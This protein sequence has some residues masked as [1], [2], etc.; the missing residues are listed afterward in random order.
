MKIGS[1]IIDDNT[2]PFLIAEIG[3]NHNGDVGIARKLI[4]VAKAAGANAVKFQTFEAESLVTSSAPLANYQKKNDPD[5]LSQHAML[6]SLELSRNEFIEIKSYCDEVGIYFISTPFDNKSADFLDE[7]GVAAIKISSADLTNHFLLEHVSKLNSPLII[8]TGMSSY[9][10]V[11]DAISVVIKNKKKSDL[12]LLHCVSN[13]PADPYDANLLCL[14]TLSQGFNITVGWSDHT[15]DSMTAIS[16]VTLG[17]CIFE[18]HITLDKTMQGPDHKASIEPDDFKDY[19]ETIQR[20]K[21]ILGDGVKR[22]MP[23]EQNTANVARRSLAASCNIMKGEIITRNM[24]TMLRPGTGMTIS[25][26]ES[27]VGKKA[28]ADI[29]VNTLFEENM[30][31]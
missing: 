5:Q 14:K 27:V 6:K 10:E 13:Y 24:I 19:V 26:L 11:E 8:S 18:K 9:S 3:V 7:I 30:L 20:V 28:G 22:I 23:S 25:S 4:D 1:N 17:A 15:L 2:L 31:S 21:K 29:S 12:A 16:A